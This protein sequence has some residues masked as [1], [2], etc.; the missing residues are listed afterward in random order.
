MTKINKLA[1]L[2]GIVGFVTSAQAAAY[3]GDIL[4]GFS[5]GL[6]NDVIYDLGSPAAITDGANWNLASVTSTFTL[7]TVNWGIV[8]NTSTSGSARLLYTTF[9][10]APATAGTGRGNGVNIADTA[11]YQNFPAAGA[12]QHLTIA[13][14]DQNS[15]NSQTINPTLTS[16][17]QNAWENP[18][19][20]GTTSFSFWKVQCNSSAPVLLGTF[21]LASSGVL[22]F[23][24]NSV[25]S[26]PPPPQITSITRTGNVSTVSFTTTN[27]SFTYKLWYTNSTGLTATTSQW[28]TSATTVTG[29]GTV[30]SIPDTTT[31]ANRFYRVSVQ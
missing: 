30:N 18:N 22:T 7:S 5:D 4:V 8:G 9:N 10:A 13:P 1:L 19:T 21:N 11:L 20:V 14:A 16:Q 3:N 6:G 31:D 24:T 12:G 2:A 27:G 15:W 25:V 28:A 29:N 17:Y 23:H 26:A